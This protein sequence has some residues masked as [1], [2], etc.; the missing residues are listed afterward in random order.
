VNVHSD[1]YQRLNNLN[2]YL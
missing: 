1:Y 2:I